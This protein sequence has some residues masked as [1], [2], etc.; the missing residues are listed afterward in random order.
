[1]KKFIK[2]VFLAAA[3]LILT[4][5]MRVEAKGLNGEK[6]IEVVQATQRSTPIPVNNQAELD[7]TNPCLDCHTDKQQLV[8][9]ARPEIVEEKES[10]GVG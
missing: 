2:F 5:C 7:L 10:K 8:E 3:C 4:A 9:N 1:L 6:S